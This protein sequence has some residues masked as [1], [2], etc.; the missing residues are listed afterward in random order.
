MDGVCRITETVNMLNRE[1]GLSDQ[2]GGNIEDLFVFFDVS[3]PRQLCVFIVL[4]DCTQAC[5]YLSP[6]PGP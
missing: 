3:G 1:R 4:S 2:E 5:K 6:D